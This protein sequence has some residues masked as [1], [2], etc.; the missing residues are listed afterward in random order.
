MR[1]RNKIDEQESGGEKNIDA[2]QLVMISVLYKFKERNIYVAH[3]Y[4]NTVEIQK[5]IV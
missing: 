4:N 3:K 2:R 1:K 5:K